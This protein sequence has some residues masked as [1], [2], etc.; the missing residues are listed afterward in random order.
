MRK[1]MWFAIGFG[2]ACALAVYLLPVSILLWIG[3][4]LLIAAVGG[5]FIPCKTFGKIAIFLFLGLSVGF[6]RFYFF[7]SQHLVPARSLD[8]QKVELTLE[9]TDFSFDSNYGVTVDG[10]TQ[11]EGRTYQVRAYLHQNQAVTPGTMIT[12]E[13]ELRYTASGSKK[14]ATYHSGNG[15][16]L[17]AYD[18]EMHSINAPSGS[19]IIYLPAYLRQE[20]KLLLQQLFPGD[21][22]PFAKA[23]LLGDTADL[24]YETNSDLGISGIRHVA[25]VSG[26]HV[27]ILFSMVYMVSGRRKG[28]TIGIGVP[29]L[30]LFMAISGFS[31]SIM[32]ASMMQLLMLL[33]MLFKKE[34]D[35][36]TGLAFAALVM[37]CINPLVV[38]SVGFQLSVASVAGIL[39]FSG[40]ISRWLMDPKRLGRFRNK[41]LLLCSKLAA[42]ASVS[43]GAML[44]TTPLTAFY[45]GTV[46]L[47]SPVTNLLCLSLVTVFFCG[48]VA[49]C[50]FGAAWLP[51]G[52]GIAWIISWVARFVLRIAHIL[53]S[54]PL[55]AVYTESIYIVAWLVACYL[56]LAVFLIGKQKRPVILALCTVVSLLLSLLASWVEPL[57]D[58]YRMTVLDVGQGQCV[59][60]QSGGRTYMVDCGGS[61]G[62]DA[63]D[64]AAATLLSQGITRLDGL[65]LTHYDADHVGGAAYLLGRV[66]AEIL[67]LPEGEDEKGFEEQLLA[68]F[69]GEVI[70]GDRD[71]QITWGDSSITVFASKYLE[72][73]N[74]T[75]LCVLFQ[76]EECDILITGDRGALGET[77]LVRE[78]NIPELDVLIIGHHGSS[79]STGEALLEATRPK[80]AVISVGAGNP[81]RHPSAATLQRLEKFGCEVRRTDLEGTIIIRG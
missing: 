57:M 2:A 69:R 67:I 59:L 26:L 68:Q 8:G 1:L 72:N 30:L 13:F 29:V 36:P 71:L 10:K 6:L 54:I 74:E 37:L 53:A 38:T 35:P 65:I 27:S 19:P 39:L 62:D 42:S 50:A 64:L 32:R 75:S 63:A 73:S 33:A 48:I 3:I 78:S 14:E 17:L 31:P 7:D 21:V 15:I 9:T 5:S 20:L 49:A 61:Y 23:L 52:A 81:Y 60:L 41:G 24:D 11:L 44:I 55:A 22:Q 77:I 40:R 18:E 16:L 79:G 51:L 47:I 34:Y 76:E 43:L 80:V 4:P 45:F 46:S 58:D 56:L 70:R 25:A 28:L 12:G 66:P